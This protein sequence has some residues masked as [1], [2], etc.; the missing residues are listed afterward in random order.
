M[1]KS[2]ISPELMTLGTILLGSSIVLS[3]VLAFPIA[4]NID[5]ESLTFAFAAIAFLAFFGM[6]SIII[7]IINNRGGIPIL[8]PKDYIDESFIFCPIKKENEFWLSTANNFERATIAV[9]P[10]DFTPKDRESIQA[11]L[12][13]SIKEEKRL[14]ITAYGCSVGKGYVFVLGN[15]SDESSGKTVSENSD[16][17]AK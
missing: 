1:Y 6:V 17:L 15:V 3:I 13:K 9:S 10:F 14:K 12:V 5:N 4:H 2:R 11:S 16:F 7:T 8:T